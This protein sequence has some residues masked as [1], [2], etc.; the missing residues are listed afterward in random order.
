MVQHTA[1][2]LPK[3]FVEKYE[4]DYYI[5]KLEDGRY[6]LNISSKCESKG[7]WDIILGLEKLLKDE[8]YPVYCVVLWEDGHIDRHNLITGEHEIMPPKEG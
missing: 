2:V 5:D 1:V 7:H 3:E 4:E 6:M 8:E